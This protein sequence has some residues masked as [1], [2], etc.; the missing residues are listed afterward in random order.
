MSVK[1]FK[2]SG[3][4]G[5]VIHALPTVRALGGGILYLDP[6]GG[7]K[8]WIVKEPDKNRTRLKFNAAAIDSVRPLLLLQEYIQEV[9][10]WNGEAVDYNLDRFRLNIS[11]KG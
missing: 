3:E 4:L 1:T 9:R 10:C 8:E 2:H 6:E 7:E 11:D 5:D